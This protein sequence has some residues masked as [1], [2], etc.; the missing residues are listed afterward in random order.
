[1][2]TASQT[3]V[4]RKQNRQHQ[5][6]AQRQLDGDDRKRIDVQVDDEAGHEDHDQQQDVDRRE[7]EVGAEPCREPLER[8]AR[9]VPRFGC[10]FEPTHDPD[11]FLWRS[12]SSTSFSVKP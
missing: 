2:T 7:A 8:D 4:S 10:A 3:W 12:P 6:R 1:M 5:G 9:R 11:S